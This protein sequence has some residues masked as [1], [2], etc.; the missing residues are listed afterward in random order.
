VCLKRPRF[1][2]D[3]RAVS[4][5]RWRAGVTAMGAM[6]EGRSAG[7]G[8]LGLVI[9]YFVFYVPYSGLV[10]ALSSGEMP[11]LDHSVGGLV[12]LPAAAL[13]QLA[14]MPLVLSAMGWWR[15]AHRRAVRG[16]RVIM[17]ARTMLWASFWMALIIGTTTLNYTFAGASILLMLLLMRGGVLILSPV[18]DI[19]RRRTVRARSWVALALSLTAVAVALGDVGGYALGLGGVLSVC[20]YLTGYAGRF[21]IM[22]RI[23]KTGDPDTDRRYFVD[24]HIGAPVCLLLLCAIPAV[25]GAGAWGGELREGFTGFLLTPAAVPAFAIGVLYET[26]FIFGTWIY[27]DRREYSWAV[28]VNRCASLFAGLVSGFALTALTGT[29]RPGNAQLA[30][31]VFIAAAG[32]LLGWAERHE[33]RR[34]ALLFV[35][36]GNT[37]RSPMAAAIAAHEAA[38]CGGR[39]RV[40]V[41]SAGLAVRAPGAPLSAEA[42]TALR[43]IG[44]PVPAHHAARAL[45]PRLCL[46][47]DAIFCMTGAQRDAVIRLAPTAAGRTH[48]LAPDA[49]LPDPAGRPPAAYRDTARLLQ[50]TVRARLREHVPI[51]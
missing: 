12:L 36:G 32:I 33:A 21:T 19:L 17:P 34:R 2:T 45:T 38:T 47:A 44:V 50:R 11:G 31:F 14:V 41:A 49:D 22:S 26:L 27:L 6:G 40:D 7:M 3:V 29:A 30:A 8:I 43:E 39:V 46:T 18:V 9:G 4:T 42:A 13:G 20:T 5:S 23:A 48:C 28:P 24:E 16:R 1:A 51:G 15:Y 25:T 37:S 35:C 10:K